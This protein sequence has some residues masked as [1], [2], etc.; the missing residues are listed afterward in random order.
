VA[1]IEIVAPPD[2][3]LELDEDIEEIV[4]ELDR[5]GHSPARKLEKA[6]VA[7]VGVIIRIVKTAIE[8][9]VLV[10]QIR[11]VLRRT[12]RRREAEGKPRETVTIYGPNGDVLLEVEI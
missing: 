4:E 8:L 11:E 6:Q 10:E 9:D 7:Y 1:T 12:R 2:R 5:L 3:A